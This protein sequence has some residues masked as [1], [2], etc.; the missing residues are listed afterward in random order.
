MVGILLSL[1]ILY[2]YNYYLL[3]FYTVQLVATSPFTIQIV[4]YGFLTY[5]RQQQ[6]YCCGEFVYSSIKAFALCLHQA[7]AIG[8]VP[9]RSAPSCGDHAS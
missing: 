3:L 5:N 9:A 4:A 8:T 2:Y 1:L 7:A 6:K